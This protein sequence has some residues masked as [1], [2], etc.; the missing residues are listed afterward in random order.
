MP[1]HTSNLL[2]LLPAFNEGEVIQ[3]VIFAITE[4]GYPNICVINDGSTDQTLQNAQAA[5]VIVLTHLINRGAGAAIQTGM[6]Y[7][8]K[9]H[10][11]YVLMMDS[12]GRGLYDN[13]SVWR[14][15]SASIR[16]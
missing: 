13:V 5:G 11:E 2:I 7:A 3:K 16:S 14:G 8:R 15:A 1:L 9:H 4:A 12:D 6:A 10:Y